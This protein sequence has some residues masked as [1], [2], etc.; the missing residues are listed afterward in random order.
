VHRYEVTMTRFFA[1]ALLLLLAPAAEARPV[2]VCLI[3]DSITDGF[4]PATSSYARH[5]ISLNAGLDFGVS[6]L[7]ESGIRIETSVGTTSPA[8][9]R[10]DRGVP[11][12]GCT[13]VVLLIGT[14]DLPSGTTGLVMWQGTGGTTGVKRLCDRTVAMG[15]K[16]ILCALLPRG[17]GASWS[18]GLQTQL[19]AF[20]APMAAYA[21]GTTIIYADTYTALL[22]PA[23]SPPALATAAG[24]A[25][26]GLHPNDAGELLIAQTIQ[27]AV[28]AA[29]GW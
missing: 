23:S 19:E 11:S 27:A 6:N 18:S 25:T 21:N 9:D 12:S 1:L 15:K 14:N 8:L 4:A 2:R 29:G 17:T 22:Q 26:D 20:N 13:H 7:A 28:V 3:G 5:L 10:F 16:C 24:G